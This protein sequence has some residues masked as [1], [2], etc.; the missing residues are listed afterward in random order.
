M[1]SCIASAVILTFENGIVDMVVLISPF[2]VFGWVMFYEITTLTSCTME[3][4]AILS[5]TENKFHFFFFLKE[6][7]RVIF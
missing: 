3:I 1:I 7:L 5:A 6:K 4:L 2:I